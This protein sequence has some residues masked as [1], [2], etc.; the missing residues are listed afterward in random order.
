MSVRVVVVACLASLALLAGLS[1]DARAAEASVPARERRQPAAD[2][3]DSVYVDATGPHRYSVFVPPGYDASRRWPVVLF[4]HGAGERGNDGR[5]QLSVGLGPIVELHPDQFPAVIVFPQVEETDERILTAWSPDNPDGKRA[6]AILAEVERQYSI[7][8]S[9]RVLAGWSMGGYG[10]WELAAV[11][12]PGF[13]S[14]AISISGGAPAE[15]A[16][17]LPKDLPFWAIH[18]AADRIVEPQQMAN[19]VEAARGAGR[20]V[21]S[22]TVDGE[23][24]GVWQAVF[25]RLE[26]RRWMFAPKSV[27]PASLDW[28]RETVLKLKSDNELP[29]RRFHPAAVISRAVAIRIGN[30]AFAELARGI[31]EAIPKERLE[32]TVKDIERSVFYGGATIHAGIRGIRWTAEL[33]AAEITASEAERLVIR[34]GLRE[35]TLHASGGDLQGGG[36]EAACGPFQVVLGRRRPVWVEVAVRPRVVDGAIDLTE[37]D[38][39]FSI[40]DDNWLVTEP[41]WANASGEGLTPDLVKV[42]VVGGMYRAKDK[43]EA[44]VR[45]LI[46]PLIERIERR[47]VQV[48]PEGLAS[49]LW[50]L[51]T[52]PPRARLIPEGIRTDSGG[53]SVTVGLAIE[54]PDERKTTETISMHAAILESAQAS[55]S[56]GIAPKVLSSVA[57]IF[58]DD[59]NARIDV[60]DLSDSPLAR[61]GDERLLRDV[62]PALGDGG[63]F[64][65][66]SVLSLPE[67]FELELAAGSEE[68]PQVL[69]LRLRA[70]KVLMEVSRRPRDRSRRWEKCIDFDLAITQQLEVRLLESAPNGRLVSMAWSSDPVI[71][72]KGRM[73]GGG[74]GAKNELHADRYVDAFRSA[75]R[76]WTAEAGK[77]SRV[78]DLAVGGARLRLDAM[79]VRGGRVWL[80][81]EPGTT[82]V[83]R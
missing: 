32:G 2:F 27:D 38:I 52:S 26:V 13:W 78:D 66:R 3:R 44:A 19:A 74:A 53:V 76:E 71:E 35:L 7:D 46:P 67:P 21:L 24:H 18:G 50:P 77:S 63:E 41:A 6:L 43:V 73:V 61:L 4:L 36:Y 14:S 69:R 64:E 1:P 58:A 47:L 82:E 34:V 42:G 28:S 62:A 54:G 5:K 56:V 48:P 72:G 17:R 15:V 83:K 8:R 59:P 70:P 12:E 57:A 20:T 79:P 39:R 37:S 31:P 22:T 49:M 75:W 55:A 11:S 30:E 10:V 60:R 40:P 9:R 16:A 25:G 45:E 81:F 68:A 80:E 29:E 23:G 65:L 51:P 33:D